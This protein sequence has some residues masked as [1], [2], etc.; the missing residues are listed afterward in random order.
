MDSFIET[1][2]QQVG[3][4]LRE[5]SNDILKAWQENIEEAQESEKKFPPLKLAITGTVDIE[6]SKIETSIKFT[7]TYQSSLSSS[8]PDP[9]Q[10]VIEFQ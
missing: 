2:N 10:A 7:A 1:I 5:R 4:L 8:L 3:E 9:D 6:K